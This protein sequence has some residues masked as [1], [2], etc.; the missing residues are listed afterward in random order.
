MLDARHRH[1]TITLLTVAILAAGAGA[2]TTPA[3]SEGTHDLVCELVWEAPGETG[4]Y[5]LGGLLVAAGWDHDGQLCVVD[6]RNRDLKVFDREGRWL[7][8]LGRAGDGPGELRDARGLVLAEDGRVG[9]L[10][11][12]PAALVWLHPDGRPGGRTSFKTTPDGE[13]G[14]VALLHLVQHPDGLMGYTTASTLRQGRISEKHWIVPLDL[15]GA[16]GEPIYF[17]DVTQPE[18]GRDGKLDEGDYYDVWAARWAPDG[19]GGAWIAAHRDRYRIDHRDRTGALVGTIELPYDPVRRDDL[20]RRLAT[21]RLQRKRLIA[22]QVALRDTAPVVR[23]LR[24]ADDGSLWVDLDLGGRGPSPGTIAWIDVHHRDQGWQRR[25]RLRGPFDPETD[26]WR[27]VDD[28]HVVVLGAD[29]DDQPVLR[30]LRL[31]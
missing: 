20:G 5:L 1:P 25:L 18:P 6:Y 29:Q 24:L 8:T 2:A 21:E 23:S 11:I 26:Q 4:E 7:R 13:G 27:P 31:P 12:F 14:F 3:P 9:L 22:D 16:F 28:R 19:E 30:L 10:Q 15:E 17:A